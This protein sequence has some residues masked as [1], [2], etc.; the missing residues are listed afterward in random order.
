MMLEEGFGDLYG[1]MYFPFLN[2]ELIL[3]PPESSKSQVGRFAQLFFCGWE[4][5]VAQL[6][7]PHPLS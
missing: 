4:T 5:P 3:E 1:N 7:Q 6:A 2:G